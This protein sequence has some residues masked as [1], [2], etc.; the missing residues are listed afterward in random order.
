MRRR[1]LFG[2]ILTGTAVL[3]AASAV[4]QSPVEPRRP[5]QEGFLSR[6]IFADGKLWVLSD[7]GV[8]SS[9]AEGMGVRVE[10]PFAMP[11]LDLIVVRGAPVVITD[12]HTAGSRDGGTASGDAKGKPRMMDRTGRQIRNWTV[13]TRSAGAWT[14]TAT[15]PAQGDK[16]AA[17]ACADDR[18]LVL[19]NRRLI[20]L[21]GDELASVKLRGAPIS[22]FI[23]AVHGTADAL[24]VGLNGGEFGGGL[25]RVD[26][27]TGAVTAIDDG[28][29][30]ETLQRS[31]DDDGD[32]VTGIVSLPWR[33]E[34]L[35]VSIG[36]VHFMSRGRI[37]EV[38]GDAVR[39]MHTRPWK[40][41]AANGAPAGEP[42]P[43]SE[44]RETVAFFGLVTQGD[45]LLAAGLDGVHR[46]Q[47]DGSVTVT[48]L[49]TFTT[50]GEIDVSFELPGVV[51]VL[52]GINQRRSIS[53]W[54]PM[55]VAR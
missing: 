43:N 33:P 8:V 36:L 21:R 42:A 55:I 30:A 40:A 38:W 23:A 31:L 18:L 53:G 14:E 13:H 22:G 10:H 25:R 6:A 47:A 2:L 20:D 15:V 28:L 37:V 24:Y 9:I 39:T 12:E 7:A 17:L 32:P 5:E 34:R 45:A 29:P 35:A 50:I 4:A 54:V 49:P 19:T 52:T 1:F 11:V 26:L 46:L 44:S 51:L 3:L 27:A 48:P 41:E 16:F